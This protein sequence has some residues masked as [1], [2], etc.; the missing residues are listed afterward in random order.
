MQTIIQ[1]LT[2]RKFLLVLIGLI[3]AMFNDQWQVALG[4]IAAYLAA[5]GGNDIAKVIKNK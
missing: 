1:K 5:E 3:A 4:I 2:S